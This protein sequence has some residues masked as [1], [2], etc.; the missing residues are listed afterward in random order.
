[1]RPRDLVY[2]VTFLI[3]ILV[4]WGIYTNPPYIH[5]RARIVQQHIFGAQKETVVTAAV[6]KT[7]HPKCSLS[8]NCPIDHFAFQIRSGAATVVGPKICF[9]GNI[10]MSGVMNNVGPGLNLVLVNGENGKIETFDFFNMYSGETADIL[11]FLKTIKPGMI[12]LVASF[13][14]AA[15]KMND[16]IRDIFVGLGSSSIKDVKFRDNWVF[17]GGAGTEQ[18]SPFEKL[19]ANDQNANIYGNWPEMVEIAG[20]FPKKV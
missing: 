6:P 14:D 8:K 10:V 5:E 13:D 20:C 15:T 4:I 12:V 2:A 18:K 7:S 3:V 1:M 11:A 9:D 19:A 16:E 17:A